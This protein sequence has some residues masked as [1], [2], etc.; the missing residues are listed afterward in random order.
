MMSLPGTCALCGAWI[1][2]GAG[3]GHCPTCLLRFALGGDS[4][5]PADAIGGFSGD[6]TSAAAVS[7]PLAG[8][9]LEDE[10]GRGGMG[11]VFRARQVRLDRFVAVKLL[12][13]GR[14]AG[15]EAIRRFHHEA[16]A[17][18]RLRHPNI[19]ATHDFGVSDGQPYL[20]MEW[21]AGRHLG[22]HIRAHPLP[23]ERAV[24]YVRAL[25]E[26]IHYAHTQGILHRDLKPSNVLI[27]PEDQPRLTDFG[28]SK[29]LGDPLGLTLTGEL[30]GSP[31]YMAPEQIAGQTGQVGP[32]ADIYSLGAI[33][34]EC[35]T[36]RPPFLAA[37]IPATL[38]QVQETEPVAPRLLN[39]A[40]P[41]DLETLCLKCLEKQAARRF[42]NARELA[43]E[44]GRVLAGEPIRSRPVGSLEKTWRWCRRHPRL[45]FL[46]GV[47]GALSLAVGLLGML[48]TK[49]AADQ[50]Q[51]LVRSF[52]QS[53]D[54]RLADRDPTGALLWYVEA[55]GLDR[56]GLGESEG[57]RMRI[58]SVLQQCPEIV[59]LLPH[60]YPVQVAAF[61]EDGRRVVTL[62]GREPG[63]AGRGVAW[64]GQA[65]LWDLATGQPVFPPLPYH[66]LPYGGGAFKGIGFRFHPLG[67]HDQRI[68]TFTTAG[69]SASNLTSQ[70]HVHDT[71]TGQ[72]IG[73]PLEHPG[74]ILFAEFSPDG[75][76]LVVGTARRLPDG[77]QSG[78]AQV[79]EV[80]TGRRLRVLAHDAAVTAARFHPD[81]R[82][83]LTACRDG[84]ARIWD[85]LSGQLD[86]PPMRHEGPLLHAGFDRTGRRLATASISPFRA[87]LWD[88]A[89]GKA[90]TEPLVHEGFVYETC[91]SPDDRW[92]LSFGFD[93]TT[94]LWHA[95]SG[96]PVFPPQHYPDFVR[97]AKF[98]PDGRLVA[99]ALN[100]GVVV[101]WGTGNGLPLGAP[102]FHSGPVLDLSFSPDGQS[103]LT[104]E[105]DGLARV[106]RPQPAGGAAVTVRHA[107]KVFHAEFSP[108]GSRLLTASADG[109][110][111]VWDAVN[112]REL[113]PPLRHDARVAH[114][115]F[116]PDGRTIAT[117]SLDGTAHIWD[118]LN[119]QPR[120]PPL[121]HPHEV[122]H[123]AFDASGSSLATACGPWV[124][125]EKAVG[126]ASEAA[127]QLATGGA[128]VWNVETGAAV[129]G[130]LRHQAAVVQATFSPDGRRVLT[131]SLDRVAQVWD[132][133]TGTPVLPSMP[134]D[135]G[136]I[137][138]RFSPDGRLIATAIGNNDHGTASVALW[139]ARTGRQALSVDG[140]VAPTTEVR[141][142]PDGTRLV[143]AG[144]NAEADLWEVRTGRKTSPS[145]VHLRKV[146]DSVFSP[147]ARWVATASEDGMAR[148]WD[149][150]R[151]D[152]VAQFST[153][154]NRVSC[155]AFSPDGKRLLAA[156]WDGTAAIWPLPMELRP[157]E[158]LRRLAGLLA[159]RRIDPSGTL[160]RLDAAAIR[161][162]WQTLKAKYPDAFRP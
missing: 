30:L 135:G 32:A 26:A 95:D 47:L 153:G 86:V 152:V 123:V 11:V 58:A 104:G 110:A 20:A 162:A 139:D 125:G 69:E 53:G 145:L 65:T 94:R 117:A 57:H 27:D 98:S 82:R 124:W 97:R 48:A 38:R 141:F 89:T 103:L 15:P 113:I 143:A 144:G 39:P 121:R 115:T 50:R 116:S 133:I 62:S 119:G 24:R 150:T 138:A 151:G 140:W 71:A 142:S 88:S 106:W 79:W 108:D 55:L 147:D 37:T 83:I 8:Y 14:L 1:P 105:I 73:V 9:E 149:A 129:A 154:S 161:Q 68:F 107:D 18:A 81:G 91:F 130:P 131:A 3:E 122:W 66:S 45:A 114:A 80:D 44:L 52:V 35:L 23:P 100:D 19:V 148:I 56:R 51:R 41:R 87:R 43:E 10:I 78:D 127:K 90:L 93:A 34:Y 63:L 29:R 160:D 54:R 109:T 99:A 67:F 17:A 120:T 132:A 6:S 42:S 61:T 92:V 40:I 2:R 126:S 7:H 111:R 128:W 85:L 101:R 75:R 76:W 70:V 134:H 46:A 13:L 159:G 72:R 21:I 84:S 136:V 74:I 33:L 96:L 31:N 25:A 16:Q 36:G 137:R 64:E 49:Q 5:E 155:V 60:P 28:L 156:S 146:Y 22:E 118:A 59:Q 102:L 158:D 4:A 12:L 112:G 77:S 157:V